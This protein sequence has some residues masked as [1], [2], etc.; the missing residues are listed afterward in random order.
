MIKESFYTSHD[1]N[2][3]DDEKI[4]EMRAKYGWEGYGLYWALI[5]MM[6]CAS[7]NKLSLNKINGI[8][9]A[10]SY[11]PN[12]LAKFVDSLSN[13]PINLLKKNDKYF[14]SESLLIRISM[15][16][17]KKKILSEAGKKGALKRWKNKELDSHPITT[18]IVPQCDSI[19]R[20]GKERKEKKR[21]EELKKENIK[22][23]KVFGEFENVKL[24]EKEY[25]KL[26]ERF[27]EKETKE[28]IETLSIYIE[29]KGKKYPSHYA[30]ILAWDRKDKRD[31]GQNNNGN[32]KKSK[33]DG[34]GHTGLSEK[35]Y[36]E[37]L[38]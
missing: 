36:R 24:T 18:P 33:G 12:S 34:T 27:S 26:I 11:D 4:L 3:K 37:D 23:K 19:A 25:S 38:F 10:L 2:A 17:M 16:K 28:K 6:G 22:E 7:G 31:N 35:N 14:W 5:E 15:R 1:F 9:I 13:S 29:S 21:K 30:T 32:G 20:K 8:A